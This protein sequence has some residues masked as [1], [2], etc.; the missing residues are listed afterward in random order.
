MPALFF[1][2][3]CR[4]T[5]EGEDY[6]GRAPLTFEET[7][8]DTDADT[9]TDTDTDTD[10][11]SDADADT[12]SDA[13]TIPVYDHLPV[14]L[15]DTDDVPVTTLYK[16]DGTVEVITEHDGTLNDLADAPRHYSGPMGIE[17]HGYSSTGYP[18]LS[19]SFETRDE[20]GED[21]DV[22]LT[23]L[24]KD[25]DWVLIASYGD[26]AYVRNRLMFELG[27][28]LAGGARW[29]PESR[30]VEVIYN[31]DYFGVYTLTG[32]VKRDGSRLDL[33]DPAPDSASGD[34]SGGYVFKLE[35]GRD[36]G[37][38]TEAG[39][40]VS[41]SDP[42]ADQITA[43]QSS[44]LE[45]Y[46]DGFETALAGG[47]LSDID[48][49]AWIDH[50]LL[51][52]LSHNIDGMRLSTYLYKD[53]GDSPLVLG[54]L[55]DFD[56]SLG[57]I[58]ECDCYDTDGW[59]QDSLTT[60][61]YGDQFAFWWDAVRADEKFRDAMRCR[62][63]DLRAGVLASKALDARVD[64]LVD[65]I[66]DVEPRDQDR[67]DTLGQNVGFNYFVGNTLDEEVDYLKSWL[68][69]RAAWMDDNLPGTCGG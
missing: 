26:K 35:S 32:R 58:V 13:D 1:L 30:F 44:Y 42:Q 62:W 55:W 25:S 54:P 10:A 29:E 49:A 34:V 60:C 22:E 67:W 14:I 68:R 66:R 18:K 31:G 40:L 33:A 39:T 65:E 46:V 59:I 28:E 64:A 8:A 7:D 52:E 61:G 4:P 57:N 23:G 63:E 50:I 24:G 16:I 20:M 5:P 21:V 27:R 45:D 38:V 36:D 41:Y 9:D 6:S 56:R 48:R 11:D 53:A 12:D 47:D 51:Q 19:F 17:M 2:L 69:D 3:A 15:L 43:E 37:W